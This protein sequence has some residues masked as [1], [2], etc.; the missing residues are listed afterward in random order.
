MKKSLF[1]AALVLPMLLTSCG[2][3]SNQDQEKL[4]AIFTDLVCVAQF[5]V[6]A[7]DNAK[8]TGQDIDMKAFQEKLESMSKEVETSMKK[9]YAKESDMKAAYMGLTDKAGFKKAV[10]EAAAKKCNGTQDTANKMFEEADKD[11]SK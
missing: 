8:T 5:G 2:T 4:T 3:A 10:V 6:T 9:A 11:T 7:A 1:A